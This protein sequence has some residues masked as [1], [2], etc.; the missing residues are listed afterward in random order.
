MRIIVQIGF[1]KNV[2][3]GQI[4]AVSLNGNDVDRDAIPGQ[5]LTDMAHRYTNCWYL[6]ELECVDGDVIVIEAKTGIRQKGP[7]DKRTFRMS[8][9]VNSKAA[10]RTVEIP[11]VGQWGYPLLKGRVEE[12]SSITKADERRQSA[13]SMLDGEF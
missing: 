1:R 6:G 2:K 7:D 8:F 9:S 12:V 13:E 4:V 11:N 3:E 5:Y 10:V